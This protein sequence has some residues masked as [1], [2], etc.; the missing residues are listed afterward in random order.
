MICGEERKK[1]ELSFCGEGFKLY[2]EIQF[3]ICLLQIIYEYKQYCFSRNLK[4]EF[5]GIKK[6]TKT[7]RS[8]CLKKFRG[9]FSQYFLK[10]ISSKFMK[11]LNPSKT[12][13]KKFFGQKGLFHVNLGRFS[14]LRKRYLIK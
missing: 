13:I 6:E 1:K 14:F 11:A 9:K 7:R 12:P 2:R 5:P 8:M 4:K 10:R 3:I